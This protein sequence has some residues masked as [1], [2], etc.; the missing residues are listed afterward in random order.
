MFVVEVYLELFSVQ[1]PPVKRNA[2][3]SELFGIDHL[4]SHS[5]EVLMLIMMMVIVIIIPIV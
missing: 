3:L 5:F 1:F 2:C 4:S